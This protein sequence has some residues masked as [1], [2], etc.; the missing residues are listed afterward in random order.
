MTVKPH[1]PFKDRATL[2]TTKI[3]PRKSG[4]SQEA[5]WLEV[6]IQ[7]KE[8]L[9]DFLWVKGWTGLTCYASDLLNICLPQ[10]LPWRII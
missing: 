9:C 3:K 6:Q 2:Q 8:E 7:M 4:S 5:F 10:F 1:I